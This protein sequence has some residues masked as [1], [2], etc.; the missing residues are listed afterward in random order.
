[1]SL[2]PGELR[3]II[4]Q[5]HR[6]SGLRNVTPQVVH[7][8]GDRSSHQSRDA[9]PCLRAL[10]CNRDILND[11]RIT[12]PQVQAVRSPED[13]VDSAPS[14]IAQKVK[15][16]R[17]DTLS[18]RTPQENS[19][20]LASSFPDRRLHRH[21]RIQLSGSE[22]PCAPWGRAPGKPQARATS[23]KSS[24]GPTFVADEWLVDIKNT[25]DVLIMGENPVE[26]HPCGFAG[27]RNANRNA[28]M[29]LSIRALR[30]SASGCGLVRADSRWNRHRGVSVVLPTYRE[31]I[32]SPKITYTTPTRLPHY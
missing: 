12:R 4:C 8:E 28:K 22:E 11:R 7:V 5:H 10:R 21:Q 27:H 15:K 9:V 29:T 30:A 18:K 19:K 2:L 32:V 3:V 20:S 31:I 14:E 6:R 16:T 13:T 26:N 24:L 23:T 25:D 1:M 17:D